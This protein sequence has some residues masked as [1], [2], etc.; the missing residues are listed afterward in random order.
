MR[1][2]AAV[3][4]LATLALTTPA[5]GRVLHA[6][7]ASGAA[8]RA[9]AEAV[10]GDTVL[11]GPGLHAGPLA[12]ARPVTLRGEPGAIVEGGGRASILNVSAGG[13]VVEDLTLRGSGSRI[14]T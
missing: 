1:F 8:A 14:L 13:A 3:A 6:P 4:S 12:I 9:L 11:L 2:L 10:P 7:A 5:P